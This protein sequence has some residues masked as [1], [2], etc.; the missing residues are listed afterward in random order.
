MVVV[1]AAST[2]LPSALDDGYSLG[3]FGR[4]LGGCAEHRE[5]AG[6]DLK[7]VRVNAAANGDA[8]LLGYRA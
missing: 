3:R 8:R 7:T 2:R 1:Y 6:C 4:E 5:Y